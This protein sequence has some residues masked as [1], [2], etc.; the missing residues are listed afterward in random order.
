MLQPSPDAVALASARESRRAQLLDEAAQE[1]NARGISGASFARIAGRMGLTRAALY[2]YVRDSDELIVQCYRRSCETMADDLENA[3]AA[4]GDGF[5]H[6]VAFVRLALDV[7][8]PPRAV[9]S[10]LDHLEGRARNQIT[11][12]HRTNVER[13]RTMLKDGMRDGS[14]RMCDDEVVAQTLV[15]TI[16]WIP[17]SIDW[18]E[19][20]DATYRSRTVASLIDVLANGQAADRETAFQ[21]NVRIA[22]FFSRPAGAF[23]REGSAAAKVEELLMR[24]SQLFNHRGIEGVSLDDVAAEVGATKGVLYHYFRNKTDLVVRCYKR[25]FTLYERF[26]DAAEAAGCNGLERAFTGMYLN[27]EAHLCG[28]SPLIQMVGVEALPAATRRDITHRAR[29]LQ[30]RFEGFGKQGLAD[31]SFRDID[32][33]AV[34][35]LGAGA[36]QWLPKWVPTNDTRATGAIAAET[37]AL[38]AKGLKP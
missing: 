7:E 9:L 36:F 1:F 38:F 12:A 5:E 28:L 25:A 19:G 10:E 23:D 2:Y 3:A 31:G 35:Q 8:R 24:A 16:A 37:M 21:P 29:K 22:D 30:R 18:V 4:P 14:I 15:G 11:A 26:A 27:I 33:D 13:L 34:A 20:T 17:L 6:I 32:F